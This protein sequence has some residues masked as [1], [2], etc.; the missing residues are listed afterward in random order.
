MW[1]KKVRAIWGNA[2]LERRFDQVGPGTVLGLGRVCIREP[3]RSAAQIHHRLFGNVRAVVVQY[4]AN[5]A[6]GGQSGAAVPNAC[7][8]GFSSTPMVQIGGGR[9]SCAASTRPDR[10]SCRSERVNTARAVCLAM[11]TSRFNDWNGMIS[12]RTNYVNILL[13]LTT[14]QH[15]SACPVGSVAPGGKA[16]VF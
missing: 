2:D 4:D 7:M 6:F 9:A 15:H 1:R 11:L 16:R 13:K 8:P 12:C 3:S 10:G 5:M 14:D